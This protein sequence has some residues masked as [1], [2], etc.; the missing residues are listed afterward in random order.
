MYLT[1]TASKDEHKEEVEEEESEEIDT[2][3]IVKEEDADLETPQDMGDTTRE[4][5]DVST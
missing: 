2:G 4:P 1:H 5:T 3:D